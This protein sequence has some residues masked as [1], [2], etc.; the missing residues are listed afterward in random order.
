MPG[1]TPEA[2]LTES[3]GLL[4]DTA[5]V[6]GTE[7]TPVEMETDWGAGA[8]DDGLSWENDTELG[9]MESP[10]A[11]TKSETGIT[12]AGLIESADVI[13]RLPLY[14]PAASPE[15]STPKDI[16]AGVVPVDGV[17]TIQGWSAVMEK[18]SAAPVEVKE[19][20]CGGAS[21]VPI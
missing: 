11:A 7:T 18:P 15:G 9:E 8:G 19:I 6:N 17:A 16:V 12:V 21:R 14:E 10:A 2:A 5:A 13:L 20:T 3:H 1:L 4:V